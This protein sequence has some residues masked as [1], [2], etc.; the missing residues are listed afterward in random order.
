MKYIIVAIVLLAILI[1]IAVAK[2]PKSNNQFTDN[3]LHQLEQ[4]NS[5]HT[6]NNVKDKFLKLFKNFK[7]GATEEI[8]KNT[9][10]DSFYF[11]DTFRVLYDIEDL[12]PYL[13][14]TAANVETT[15]VD[16]LDTAYSGTDY[17]V[18]WE[19]VMVV[20]VKGEELFSRSIGMTQLRFN[21]EGKII[22]H[23][24]FWD[25]TEGFFQHLPYIGYMIRKIKSQL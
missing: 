7:S 9:Y 10:A 25:S 15:T 14:E 21:D 3:Y 1:T 16:I 18:R 19:M 5:T 4:F 12:V 11:N 2:I 13:T 23:Q 20:D 24:D 8:I 6:V 17:Y 22:F